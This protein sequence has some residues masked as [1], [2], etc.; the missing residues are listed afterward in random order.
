MNKPKYESINTKANKGYKVDIVPCEIDGITYTIP[1]PVARYIEAL[2]VDRDN[3]VTFRQMTAEEMSGF[4]NNRARALIDT[5][6]ANYLKH[7]PSNTL[8]LSKKIDA[9]DF[10]TMDALCELFER[11]IFDTV[12][13]APGTDPHAD[14]LM[15]EV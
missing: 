4:V 9:S 13:K 11:V 6:N 3:F 7:N 14:G 15:E 8:Y 12:N 10:K 1:E 5:L 2:Q